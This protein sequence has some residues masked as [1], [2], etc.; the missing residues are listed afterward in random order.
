MIFSFIFLAMAIGL[1]TGMGYLSFAAVFTVV[2]AL[3]LLILGKLPLKGGRR[4]EKMLR[5]VMPEDL[6]YMGVFEDIFEKYTVS[7]ELEKVKTTNLGSMFEASYVIV[8]KDASKE[9]AMI[10]ELR[11]RN[12]NLAISCAR[13]TIP[14]DQL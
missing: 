11:C 7:A 8:M 1:A 12:G 14:N 6:D 13:Y 5:I 10:D 4:T 3:V 9:K 2:I